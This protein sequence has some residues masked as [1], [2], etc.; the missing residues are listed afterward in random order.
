MITENQ[1][2]TLF[3]YLKTKYDIVIVDSSPIGMISDAILLNKYVDKSLFVVR[4]GY[5]KKAMMEKARDIFDQNILVNP[6]IIFNGVKKQND[7][8]G[9]NYK[10]YSQA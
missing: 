2:D 1:M 9:Y 7:S 8:Y 5:S 10:Q 3:S 6:S 4:S